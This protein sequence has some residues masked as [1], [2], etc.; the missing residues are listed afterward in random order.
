VLRTHVAQALPEALEARERAVAG[1]RGDLALL[2]EARRQADPL[3]DAI[4]D[5]RWPSSTRPTIMWK[6]FDPRSTPA[7]TSGFGDTA[8]R[9]VVR[10]TRESGDPVVFMEAAPRFPRIDESILAS[11]APSTAA[12]LTWPPISGAVRKRTGCVH[13][14]IRRKWVDRLFQ[15]RAFE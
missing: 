12:P 11:V 10:R 9:A 1:S 13:R 7:T 6:L 2:V 3:P 5:V 14:S 8:F 15:F 4:D